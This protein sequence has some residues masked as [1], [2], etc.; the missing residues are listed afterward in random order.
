MGDRDPAEHIK[1]R[2]AE[3]GNAKGLAYAESYRV[4]R[5]ERPNKPE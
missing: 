4:I 5:L 2:N 3:M 1:R